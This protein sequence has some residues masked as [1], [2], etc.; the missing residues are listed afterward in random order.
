MKRAD[1]KIGNPH[2]NNH[3]HQLSRRVTISIVMTFLYLK[4]CG[5][6]NCPVMKPTDMK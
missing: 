6:V 1:C 4:G 3:Y 5:V 2:K